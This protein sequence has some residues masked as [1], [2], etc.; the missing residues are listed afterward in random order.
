MVEELFRP[1]RDENGIPLLTEV[2]SDS[3]SAALNS[4]EKHFSEVGTVESESSSPAA[5]N[6]ATA[7]LEKFSLQLRDSLTQRIL[8]RLDPALEY[9][10]N[11]TTREVLEQAMPAVRAELQR[12]LTETAVEVI[13]RAIHQEF[14][15]ITT[16]KK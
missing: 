2:I 1:R 9:R 14:A 8:A 7:P 11:E 6:A 4:A 5:H 16:P 10:L 12:A 3:D 15:K 13:G